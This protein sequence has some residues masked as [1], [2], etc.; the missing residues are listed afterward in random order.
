MK[1][2][3]TFYLNE[4]KTSFLNIKNGA[5]KHQAMSFQHKVKVGQP[6]DENIYELYESKRALAKIFVLS[7]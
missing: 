3:S 1:H 2:R 6:K 5:I 4:L 7:N